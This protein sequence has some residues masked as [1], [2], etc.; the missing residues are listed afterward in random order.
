MINASSPIVFNFLSLQCHFLL[1]SCCFCTPEA[2]GPLSCHRCP[3]KIPPPSSFSGRSQT[4][5][6]EAGLSARLGEGSHT[7]TLGGFGLKGAIIQRAQWALCAAGPGARWAEG[8]VGQQHPVIMFFN[9]RNYKHG[10]GR[11][12]FYSGKPNPNSK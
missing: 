11:R 3:P 12:C 9:R 2:G 1:H 7:H 10:R 6:R 4:E 8:R 5:G